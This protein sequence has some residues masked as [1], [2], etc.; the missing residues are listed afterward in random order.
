[1]YLFE[2]VKGNTTNVYSHY[3]FYYSNSVGIFFLFIFFF[4]LLLKISVYLQKAKTKK[5]IKKKWKE[6]IITKDVFDFINKK[7]KER[8]K[9]Y[10]INI[11]SVFQNDPQI[12]Y[13]TI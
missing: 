1:M 7:A 3:L 6:S 12:I 9:K 11:H 4:F 13:D 8:K 5:K 10:K 2:A